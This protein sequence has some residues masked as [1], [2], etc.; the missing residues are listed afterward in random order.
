MAEPHMVVPQPSSKIDGLLIFFFRDNVHDD[1]DGLNRD[2]WCRRVMYLV[3]TCH[4]HHNPLNDAPVRYNAGDMQMIKYTFKDV[5]VEHIVNNLQ[6]HA[7]RGFQTS[8][9]L[10]EQL[11]T[12]VDAAQDSPSGPHILVLVGMTPSLA[13]VDDFNNWYTHEHIHLLSRVP[14]WLYS[15][16]YSIVACSPTELGLIPPDYLAIHAYVSRRSFDT[17]PYRAATSTPWRMRVV[18]EGVIRDER[19]VLDFVQILSVDEAKMDKL[20]C[21]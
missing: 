21:H 1:P 10:Y 14:G 7:I 12:V 5:D 4:D 11:P 18:N 3:N 16:R 13:L 6:K 15:K 2:E 20:S 9:R 17:E 8:W 19:S